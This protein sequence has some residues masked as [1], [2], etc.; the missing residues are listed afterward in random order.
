MYRRQGGKNPGVPKL[1]LYVDILT[2][3]IHCTGDQ[4]VLG[5]IPVLVVK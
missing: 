2:H 1:L 3:G 5:V 4:V